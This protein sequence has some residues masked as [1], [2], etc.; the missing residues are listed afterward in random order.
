[1]EG[2]RK[3]ACIEGTRHADN[4]QFSD[5]RIHFPNPSTLQA[6]NP[7]TSML[8]I[9]F[10][11]NTSQSPPPTHPIRHPPSQPSPPHSLISN[12]TPPFPDPTSPPP[13]HLTKPTL[14]PL[15]PPHSLFP[16]NPPSNPRQLH[17]IFAQEHPSPISPPE[18]G[19]LGRTFYNLPRRQREE[20]SLC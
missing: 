7:R 11:N 19:N 4:R 17:R 16:Q 12:L 6:T 3:D 10:L 13:S 20:R 5:D 2:C 15:P 1:M 9:P 14:H 8:M 18:R